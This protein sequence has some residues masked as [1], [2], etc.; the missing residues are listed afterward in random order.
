MLLRFGLHSRNR[1]PN[2]CC[3][4]LQVGGPARTNTCSHDDNDDD[5]DTED[6]HEVVA[7]PRLMVL[8]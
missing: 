5:D 1:V 8:T 4:P 2:P 3:T 7:R 6:N